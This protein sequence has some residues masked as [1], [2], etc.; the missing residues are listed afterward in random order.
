MNAEAEHRRKMSA[1][2][3]RKKDDEQENENLDAMILQTRKKNARCAE[4][5]SKI[6]GLFSNYNINLPQRETPDQP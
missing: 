3:Q 4:M 2:E 5:E 6:D 1:Y